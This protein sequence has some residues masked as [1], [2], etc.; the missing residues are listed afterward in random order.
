[1][2]R[3]LRGP[4]LNEHSDIETEVSSTDQSD[5]SEFATSSDLTTSSLSPSSSVSSSLGRRKFGTNRDTMGNYRRPGGG[6]ADDKTLQRLSQQTEV[7]KSKRHRRSTRSDSQ[8]DKSSVRSFVSMMKEKIS[9]VHTSESSDDTSKTSDSARTVPSYLQDIEDDL[10][11]LDGSTDS[12]ANSSLRDPLEV[13][14][15][16][17]EHSSR[18]SKVKHVLQLKK[19]A[20]QKKAGKTFGALHVAKHAHTKTRKVVHDGVFKTKTNVRYETNAAVQRMRPHA[21]KLQQLTHRTGNKA[22]TGISRLGICMALNV[23]R[24]ITHRKWAFGRSS[25]EADPDSCPYGDPFDFDVDLLRHQPVPIPT[26]AMKEETLLDENKPSKYY[27]NLKNARFELGTSAASFS[28][29]FF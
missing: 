9:H 21:L 1:M 3:S 17:E 24:L 16:G 2:I 29:I 28:Q 18:L 15:Q 10:A 26:L 5:D 8:Q 14:F 13:E 11:T 25:V 23:V 7:V 4:S 6:D 27:G 19:N 22:K 20:L 12:D